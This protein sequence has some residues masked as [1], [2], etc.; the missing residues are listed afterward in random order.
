VTGRVFDIKRFALHDGPGIRTTAFLKGCPLSCPWCHN[1]EGIRSE[2]VLWY[3]P[4]RCIQCRS[5][6]AACPHSVLSAHPD[7]KRFIH[8]DRQKCELS[9]A[10]V[11]ACPT[12]AL[13][14]DSRIYQAE[15]LVNELLADR[16]FFET[17]GGGVTLSGGEPL[18]Q[19]DFAREVLRMVHQQGVHTAVESTLYVS[20]KMLDSFRPVVDHW[21]VD[22]KLWDSAEHLKQTGVK[23]ERILANIRH[24]AVTGAA[25]TLRIPLIPGVTV[26]EENI[27]PTARF[28]ASLP[29]EIPLELINFN[30]LA[31]GKYDALGLPYHFREQN[32][33]FDADYVESLKEI[34]RAEGAILV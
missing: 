14:W 24:L 22:I 7:D 30:P 29:G 6:V 10:C 15:E 18:L 21:L 12:G 3:H 23:N 16:V 11:S 17:S 2:T 32:A 5:C 9:G 13:E 27:A 33:P 4:Q 28:V 34:A 8:I 26:R 1:P 19:A 20:E 31:K 25:M